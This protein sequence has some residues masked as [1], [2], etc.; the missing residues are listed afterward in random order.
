ML[1]V[2]GNSSCAD[3]S[4][5]RLHFGFAGEDALAIAFAGAFSVGSLPFR[6][7]FSFPGRCSPSLEPEVDISHELDGFVTT[8]CIPA[9]AFVFA[10]GVAAL[11]VS[12]TF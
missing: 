9:F 2:G 12:C 5:V 11:F 6:V 10:R 8:F 7:A 3:S 1:W 4:S